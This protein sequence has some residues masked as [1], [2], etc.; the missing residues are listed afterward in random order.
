MKSQG[1][2]GVNNQKVPGEPMC[3]RWWDSLSSSLQGGFQFG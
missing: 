1:F 3:T 2:H